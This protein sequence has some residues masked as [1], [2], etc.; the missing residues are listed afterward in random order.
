VTKDRERKKKET[1]N[2]QGRPMSDHTVVLVKKK[3]KLTGENNFQRFKLLQNQ[4]G[5]LLKSELITA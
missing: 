3:R 2:D 1:G 4:E 5:I